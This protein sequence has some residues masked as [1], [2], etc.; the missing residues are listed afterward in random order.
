MQRW[1]C[2]G[3]GEAHH[4]QAVEARGQQPDLYRGQEHWRC[5][6]LHSLLFV[7]SECGLVFDVRDTGGKHR[8]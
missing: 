4:Q 8:R 2:A 3:G 5:E 7:R 6:Q 1:G